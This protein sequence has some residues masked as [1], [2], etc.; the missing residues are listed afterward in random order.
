MSGIS[1]RTLRHYDDI[2]LLK[3]KRVA[4]S[5]YRIYGQ[6]EVDVL[7]QILLYRE[8]SFPLDN[9]KRLL[10][11]P[12]FDRAKAFSSHLSELHCK[13]ERLDVLIANVTQFLNARAL[14]ICAAMPVI[15]KFQNCGIWDIE[16]L[17]MHVQH[18]P[19]VRYAQA[20]S[21]LIFD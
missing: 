14:Y 16:F 5:G 20:L 10:N 1:A 21:F 12:S 11:A 8:L 18:S 19:L 17:N 9:I 4:S 7:Q 13:R 2:G 3:P 15:H 6:E